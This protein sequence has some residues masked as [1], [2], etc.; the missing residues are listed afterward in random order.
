MHVFMINGLI[1]VNERDNRSRL[2][3]DAK[4]SREDV[5]NHLF[6]WRGV[7][8]VVETGSEFLYEY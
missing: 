3:P 4:F 6:Q 5:W 8:E 2:L 1:N 7:C